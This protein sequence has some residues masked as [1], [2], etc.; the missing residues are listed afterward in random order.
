M[1]SE[2]ADLE[3]V[4][5]ESQRL[6]FLGPR[7]V[8]E[9]IEHARGFVAA[10]PS[11]AG[12]VVDLGSGGGVPGL[13]I[14]RD[15]P[16]LHVTLLDRRTKRTDFLERMV[17]RLGWHERVTVVAADAARFVAERPHRFD[18]VVAR[19]FGPPRTTLRYGAALV[20][21]GG[22]VIISEPPVGDRWD[23]AWLET[24]HLVRLPSTPSTRQ[25]VVLRTE[26]ARH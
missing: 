24:H 25:V 2:R 10:I 14:A 18:V 8:T 23:A 26:P 6:G 22:V 21:T 1:M 7:P 9:V 15:R 16:D 12:S 19:G 17:G 11:F 13:V 5:A 3:S 4:L 20:V